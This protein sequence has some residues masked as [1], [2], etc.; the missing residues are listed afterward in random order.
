MHLRVAEPE[1][2]RNLNGLVRTALREFV[3]ARKQVEFDAA[4]SRMAK[5]PAIRKACKT[6]SNE[7]M[8]AEE[9]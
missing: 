6:I 2:R 7:F 1:L 3:R 8:V 9:D 5:D 4:M